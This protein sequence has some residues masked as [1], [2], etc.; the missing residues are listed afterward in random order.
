MPQDLLIRAPAGAKPPTRDDVAGALALGR[1]IEAGT[2][3]FEIGRPATG[4]TCLVTLPESVVDG[5][6]A[7]VTMPIARA[8]FVGD[9]L[10][11]PLVHAARALGASLFDDDGTELASVETARARWRA[12]RRSELRA[13]GRVCI[14]SGAPLPPSLPARDL[15]AAHAWLVAVDALVDD[16]GPPIARLVL[17]LDAR[18]G[19]EATLAVRAPR[20][21]VVRL[22]PWPY[23]LIDPHAMGARA[24]D[25]DGDGDLA[26]RLVSRDA[27]VR[28][29]A[30]DADGLVTVALDERVRTL[31]LESPDLSPFRVLSVSELID[32]E[33][34]ALVDD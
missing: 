6:L 4:S 10:L 27:I 1:P 19:E 21:D 12:R 29:L 28:G 20:A 18:D 3:A 32:A 2:D 14:E 31:A 7:R 34:L 17:A 16:R 11:P 30:P 25:D 5:V 13:L 8:L 9:D 33:S 23:V 22:P 15:D 24:K 26:P